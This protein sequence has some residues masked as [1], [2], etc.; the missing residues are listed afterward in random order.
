MKKILSIFTIIC[1]FSCISAYGQITTTNK[2]FPI[3]Y[4][5]YGSNFKDYAL[6]YC[7][8]KVFSK[9]DASFHEEAQAM[10]GTLMERWIDFDF[11]KDNQK[12]LTKLS[13]LTDKYL[14]QF[15]G[16]Q[17]H[18][19]AKLSILKCMDLY[20]SDDLD[21]LTKEFVTHPNRTYKQD[22]PKYPHE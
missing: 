11:N 9:H 10:E 14:K 18:P 6:T 17:M 3:A 21:K 8:E 2:G 1:C 19:K 5:H 15:Y 12:T 7:L 22:N 4:R 20:H 13:A 16:S